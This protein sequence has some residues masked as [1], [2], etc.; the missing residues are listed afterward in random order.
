MSYSEFGTVPFM[1]YF[2]ATSLIP[3]LLKC[4]TFLVQMGHPSKKCAY[5]LISFN[6]TIH[7][8]KIVHKLLR[9]LIS[10]HVD[11]SLF[12]LASYGVFS[13][14]VLR[15]AYEIPGYYCWSKEAM[16]RVKGPS[17]YH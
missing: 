5:L 11:T 8:F 14:D 9:L 2:S 1:G 16:N 10:T 17:A 13:L 7:N 12:S 6:T 3:H 4:T 15:D